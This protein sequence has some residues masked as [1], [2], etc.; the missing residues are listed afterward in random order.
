MG[1]YTVEFGEEA[2]REVGRHVVR[3]YTRVFDHADTDVDLGATSAEIELGDALPV[4]AVV[5]GV[6]CDVTEDW[7]DGSTGTFDLDVG[8]GTTADLFTP[9]QVVLDG[10]A[11]LRT[12]SVLVPASGVQLTV[13]IVSSVDLDTATG[14]TATLTVY[15]A[16]PFDTVIAAP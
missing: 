15:F 3:S 13:T 1:K 10:G 12:Q 7:S 6:T 16:V 9:T 14:G 4:G 5:L 2:A 11:A 8:D